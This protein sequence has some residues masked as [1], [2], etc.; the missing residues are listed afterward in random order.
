MLSNAEMGLRLSATPRTR[1]THLRGGAV[2]GYGPV[3]RTRSRRRWTRCKHHRETVQTSARRPAGFDLQEPAGQFGPWKEVDA[4]GGRP[5]ADD[6][7]G[8]RCRRWHC[9]F[10][11][12]TPA[13]ATAHDLEL[14]GENGAGA[15]VMEIFRAVRLEWEIKRLGRFKPRPGS[16]GVSWTDALSLPLG[17]LP[18]L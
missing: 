9:N 16:A 12:S 2:R 17:E 11:K 6:R 7:R 4:A 15:R 3:T 18:V 5:R 1:R 10:M 14:L 8:R 13:T